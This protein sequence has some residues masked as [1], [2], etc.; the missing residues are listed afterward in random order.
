MNAAETF[1]WTLSGAAPLLG[2]EFTQDNWDA[3]LT[4]ADQNQ[5]KRGVYYDG[6]RIIRRASNPSS[7][8][9]RREFYDDSYFVAEKTGR[10][11]SLNPKHNVWRVIAITHSS[12]RAQGQVISVEPPCKCSEKDLTSGPHP[13]T[14]EWM[15]WKKARR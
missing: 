7:G 15:R 5:R 10:F 8:Q 9:D 2:V 12:P 3:A 14:C 11:S 6:D 13:P 1:I 4:A